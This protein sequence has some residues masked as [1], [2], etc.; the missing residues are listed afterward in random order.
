VPFHRQLF[1]VLRSSIVSGRYRR[2][3]LFPTE[4]VL[5]R[6]YAVSRATVRRALSSLE[7]EGLIDR[8]QG[9]GTRVAGGPAVQVTE[10][11]LDAHLA[12]ISSVAKESTL[13]L[14]EVE[15]VAATGLVR[16]TLNLPDDARVLRMKRV[17]HVDD[18]PIWF[19]IAYFPDWIGAKLNPV[20]FT[21]LSMWELMKDGGLDFTEIDETIGASVA[22]AEAAALLAIDIGAPLLETFSTVID[23][24]GDPISFQMTFTPP[25]RRRLRFARRAVLSDH[26]DA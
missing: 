11:S 20:K 15:T 1:L 7:G 21:E 13:Q 10:S 25:E 4:E 6:T 5:A 18:V 14:V 23:T 9:A 2:G 24:Q 26:A 17:R 22:D 8:R 16:A 12:S 3:D 19:T